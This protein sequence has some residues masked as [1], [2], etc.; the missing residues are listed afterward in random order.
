MKTPENIT[1]HGT[2]DGSCKFIAPVF[3]RYYECR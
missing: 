2:F 1:V 3:Q